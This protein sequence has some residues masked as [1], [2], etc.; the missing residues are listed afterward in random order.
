MK[1][2]IFT[3]SNRTYSLFLKRNGM[4]LKTLYFLVLIICPCCSKLKTQ[5]HVRRCVHD[6]KFM[7]HHEIEKLEQSILFQPA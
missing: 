2:K 1:M 5:N 7:I 3:G 6:S 4:Y